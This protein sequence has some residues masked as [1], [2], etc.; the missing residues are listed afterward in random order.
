MSSRGVGFNVSTDSCLTDE[1]SL[2]VVLAVLC[3]DD[4][5]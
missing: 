3:C 1:L 2:D 4:G 5:G